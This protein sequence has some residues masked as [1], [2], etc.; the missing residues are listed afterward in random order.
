MK[1]IQS[2]FLVTLVLSGCQCASDLKNVESLSSDIDLKGAYFPDAIT[3]SEV[4]GFSYNPKA[5]LIIDTDSTFVI[6]RFPASA[7]NFNDYYDNNTEGVKGYGSWSF[8]NDGRSTDINVNLHY[9]YLS[10]STTNSFATAWKLTKK[11]GEYYIYYSVG[12]PDECN[13]VRLKRN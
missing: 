10:D 4:P 13:P 7:L 12:D 3:K 5:T 1:G 8:Y 11:D 2:I 9:T 6:D